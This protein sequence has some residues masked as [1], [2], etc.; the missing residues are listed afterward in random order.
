MD[1]RRRPWFAFDALYPHGETAQKIADEFGRD[2]LL[3]WAC[4]LAAC[5]RGATQGTFTYVTDESGWAELG[6]PDPANRPDFSLD[7]F[8]SF[9]GRIKQTKKTRSGRVKNVTATRW[10]RWQNVK[11]SA[12]SG[13]LLPTENPP[14]P[15]PEGSPDSDLDLDLDRTEGQDP[16]GVTDQGPPRARDEDEH[17]HV[18]EQIERSLHAVPDPPAEDEGEVVA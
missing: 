14:E 1:A 6:L 7:D 15:R 2:G 3:V 16:D 8:W 17:H 18:G 11:K 10:G 5:K 12:A 4:F 13:A 9:T